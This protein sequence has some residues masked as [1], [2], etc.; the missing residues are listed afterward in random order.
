MYCHKN[1]YKI[2]KNPRYTETFFANMFLKQ[3]EYS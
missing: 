3:S 1:E 2:H